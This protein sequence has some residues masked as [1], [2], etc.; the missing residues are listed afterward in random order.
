[1]R[2]LPVTGAV[3]DGVD[4]LDRRAAWS[5]AA[6]P[7]RLS[8]STPIVL[9]A[10]LL[11]ERAAADGD[12]HQ[13]GLDGLAVAEVH[14]QRAARVLDLLHCFSRWRAIPRFSNCFASSAAASA[15]S[16]G[17]S[18]GSISMIVTSGPKRLKI[19]ANSQP[20]MPPPRTTSRRG[21]SVCARSPVG[22]DAPRRVEALDR[23][24][25]RERARRDDRLLE[26]DVLPALDRDRV[27]VL[28]PC[29]C[30]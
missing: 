8:N 14:G 7:L 11:D 21:T 18:F 15:S 30:P 2:E 20:M 1:M 22:V 6:M 17:I 25:Q 4:V 5:S 19:E 9:E 27:R 26:G 12:E 13:V 28:Q 3:A 24:T 23:R 16:F 10:E 29:R